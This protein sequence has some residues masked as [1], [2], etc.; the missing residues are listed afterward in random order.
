VSYSVSK[1]SLSPARRRL[2]ESM[3]QL[4]FG[5]IENLVIQDGQPIF[6][7]MPRV[8]REHKFGGENGPRAE[9][10]TADFLLKTQVIDLFKLF[11]ELGD[12]IIE[13]LETKHGLP[14]RIFVAEVPA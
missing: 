10:A 6:D 5:R 2:L 1:A 7:P 13:V 9:A 4:Y 12:G 14:F 3:Q 8:V 11:D